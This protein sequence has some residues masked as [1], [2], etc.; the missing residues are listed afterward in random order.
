MAYR[1]RSATR[2]DENLIW[3]ATMETVWSTIPEDER[4]HLDPQEFETHFREQAEPYVRGL[5]GERFVAEDE[6]GRA[7]GY[8][9][10]AEI[11]TFYS[12]KPVGFVFD[13]WVKPEH[14]GKGVGK[15]LIE[16]AFAWCRLRGL[17][18]LKL[19]VAK[20]NAAAKSLYDRMGFFEERDAMG[21]SVPPGQT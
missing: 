6:M 17:S 3:K 8:I 13:V 20:T 7:V 4:S 5:R 1:I 9:I 16:R 21:A 2:A 10:L 11:R 12:P 18:K 19:E 15:F 14:R